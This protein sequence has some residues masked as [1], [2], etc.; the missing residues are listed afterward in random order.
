MIPIRNLFEGHLTVSDLERSM[1]FFGDTL[2][3]ELAQVFP[4]RRVAF[5]WIGRPG[6]SMLGLWEVGTAPQRLSLHIAFTVELADLLN[7]PQRLRAANVVPRDFSGNPTD[8]P[9]VLAW[10][11]A[12]SL[13]FHDPDGNLLE[14]LAMLPDAPRR[15]LGVIGWTDWTRRDAGRKTSESPQPSEKS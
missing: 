7:A 10:M 1:S 9:V 15:E 13:Y 5:Y 3:L 14:F 6:Q 12:A 2:G 11:P 8:E 4:E